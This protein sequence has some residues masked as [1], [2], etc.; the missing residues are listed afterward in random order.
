MIVVGAGPAGL[1]AG[2]TTKRYGLETAIFEAEM[3]PRVL[4]PPPKSEWGLVQRMLEEADGLLHVQEEVTGLR[5]S[6]ERK[7]VETGKNV[8]SCYALIFA[9]GGRSRGSEIPGATWLMHG[10][11]YCAECDGDL[12]RGKDVVVIGSGNEAVEEALQLVDIVRKVILIAHPAKF[13]ADELLVKKAKEKGICIVEGYIV[14]K[15]EG[16][17]PSKMVRLRSIDTSETKE[18]GANAIFIARG[19]RPST[20]MIKQVGIETHRQGCIVVDQ[21]LQTNVEGI[22]AAGSCASRGGLTIL[23]CAEEGVTAGL[24]ASLYVKQLLGKGKDEIRNLESLVLNSTRH[25]RSRY[26]FLS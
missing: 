6:E 13:D 15:V 24:V 26:W 14:E 5:L 16:E 2:N 10:I 20:V 19:P 3:R 21:R 22:Y 1:A 23:T 7:V 12:F 17:M 8:Y 11:S 25:R 9:I 4:S 18:A